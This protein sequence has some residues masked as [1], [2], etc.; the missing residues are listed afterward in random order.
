MKTLAILFLLG[1]LVSCAGSVTRKDPE[2][3]SFP[4][5]DYPGSYR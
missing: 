5:T 1:A 3:P 2:E 4:Y